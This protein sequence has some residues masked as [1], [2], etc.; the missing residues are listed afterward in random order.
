ME[1]IKIKPRIIKVKK[2]NQSVTLADETVYLP[3]KIET[4]EL[5]LR[6]CLHMILKHTADMF[7]TITEIVAEEYKLD[8]TEVVKTIQG[9]P[10]FEALCADDVLLTL[11]YLGESSPVKKE[12]PSKSVEPV[13]EKTK[14]KPRA[15]KAVAA[16]LPQPVIPEVVVPEAVA[17]PVIK[18]EAAPVP[19][20]Q[21][22]V[23]HPVEALPLQPK[24]VKV[25]IV[26]KINK[27]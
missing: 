18:E 10:R 13:P 23:P 11:G 14:R 16:A 17:V 5:A 25:R 19:Q 6:A 27:Q 22:T 9:S 21:E 1:P 26:N 3:L 2:D 24:K 7:V 15:P 8:A 20:A 12:E 4:K